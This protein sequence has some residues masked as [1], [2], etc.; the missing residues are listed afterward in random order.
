MKKINELLTKLITNNEMPNLSFYKDLFN[1]DFLLLE[2]L[3]NTEHDS[4]WHSEGNVDI[5]TNMVLT[6]VYKLIYQE[7]EDLDIENKKILILAAVFHDI[8][9]AITTQIVEIDG[10]TR[11]VSPRHEEVGANYIA[12][13]LID[14]DLKYSTILSIIN[15]VKYHQIPKL[16]IIKNNTEQYKFLDLS[17]KCSLQLFYLFGIADI[18]GREC[19][20]KNQQIE[21]LELFKLFSIEY[22]IFTQIDYNDYIL[23]FYNS[24]QHLLLKYKIKNCEDV[25]NFSLSELSSGTIFTPDEGVAKYLKYNSN[26]KVI[27][28]SG[29]SGS[30]KSSNIKYFENFNIINLDN[31]RK[32]LTKSEDDQSQ[33]DEVLR[34]AYLQLKNNLRNKT[35]TIFDATNLRKDFRDKIFNLCDKYNS[36]VEIYFFHSSIKKSLLNIKKRERQ[37]SELILIKQINQ[38][39]YPDLFESRLRTKYINI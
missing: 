18:K 9:K 20:D 30:G 4:I 7:Y 35:N 13:K 2:E 3:K 14:Y 21:Y 15:I 17:N 28:F 34:I 36:L 11:V 8:G 23:I 22:N 39:Q 5:H 38:L 33:N 29:L 27:V 12:G 1:D 37:V 16:L 19:Y 6:E 10:K 25:F 26:A 24:I 32:E 31:I